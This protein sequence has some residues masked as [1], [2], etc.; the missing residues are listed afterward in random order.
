VGPKLSPCF[1]PRVVKNGSL[2]EM[3]N[4]HEYNVLEYISLISLRKLP[5]IL[6]FLEKSISVYAVESLFE[7]D[8]AYIKFTLKFM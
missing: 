1:T 8:K 6:Y 3:P 2:Y 4:L 5:P 7:I